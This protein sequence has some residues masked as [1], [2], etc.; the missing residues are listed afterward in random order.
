MIKLSYLPNKAI[1]KLRKLCNTVNDLDGFLSLKPVKNEL[2]KIDSAQILHD[3][4]FINSNNIEIISFYSQ[5]YPQSLKNI[6]DFPLI[7]YGWGNLNYLQQ[8]II[9]IIGSRTPNIT[10]IKLVENLCN[11]LNCYD[12]VIVSGM[13]RGIDSVAHINSQKTI[14]IIGTGL[15]KCYPREHKSLMHNLAEN[16]LIVSEYPLN[17]EPHKMN[18]PKRNRII[19]ALAELV[20][21]IEAKLNSGSLTTAKFALNYGKEIF[22]VPGHPYDY[23]VMGTNKLIKDGAIMLLDFPEIIE[24]LNQQLCK[25]NLANFDQEAKDQAVEN[26]ATHNI[27]KSHQEILNYITVEGVEYD[28]I[29]DQTRLLATSLNKILAEL[30]LQDFIYQD[31]YGKIYKRAG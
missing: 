31:E 8:N 29:I 24:S 9:A 6:P 2:C 30:E 11:Y 7:F 14:A 23:K 12:L 18:F 10:N 22:A 26:S 15:Q 19:A 4:N 20:V 21:I 17:M 5:F 28:D 13:A 1:N 25:N 3:Y 27:A 16:Q